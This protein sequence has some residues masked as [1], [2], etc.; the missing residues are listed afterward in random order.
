MSLVRKAIDAVS[1]AASASVVVDSA[2]SMKLLWRFLMFAIRSGLVLRK[3]TYDRMLR[4]LYAHLDSACEAVS[5][6][7]KLRI[8]PLQYVAH[9]PG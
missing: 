2:Q 5:E 4:A 6:V 8:Y 3:E 9:L 7:A 1:K